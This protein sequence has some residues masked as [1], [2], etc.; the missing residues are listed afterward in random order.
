ML[1][2]IALVI[3]SYKETKMIFHSIIMITLATLFYWY[4]GGV[5]NAI[6]SM[7]YYSIIVMIIGLIE[8]DSTIISFGIGGLIGSIIGLAIY[9][10]LEE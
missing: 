2:K 8:N 10:Y 5:D 9:T 7:F 6:L 4:F 1:L 3:M